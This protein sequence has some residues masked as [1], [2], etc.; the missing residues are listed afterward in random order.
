ME[1][2]W[3]LRRLVGSRICLQRKRRKMAWAEVGQSARKMAS[4]TIFRVRQTEACRAGWASGEKFV[5]A[6]LDVVRI[7]SEQQV[8]ME[9]CSCR[10]IAFCRQEIDVQQRLQALERQFDLPA[11][12]IKLGEAFGRKLLDGGTGDE[13]E[14]AGALERARIDAL[15]LI[16]LV[17]AQGFVSR[18]LGRLGWLGDDEKAHR[19][20]LE[21][22]ARLFHEHREFERLELSGAR[23]QRRPIERMGLG[24]G[25][26]ERVP[27]HTHNDVGARFDDAPQA[28]RLGVA[29]IGDDDILG[30]RIEPAK[31]LA[32]RRRRYL[33]FDD[34]RPMRV[35]ALQLRFMFKLC[36]LDVSETRFGLMGSSPE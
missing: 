20:R 21:T 10:F 1:S 25:Q 36:A 12:P 6:A 22:P 11:S 31:R 35:I 32:Y 4:A 8:S 2:I 33:G 30:L 14:K 34:T 15:A 26:L 18:L 9:P 7:E 23:E 24:I 19:K 5:Q 28:V 17:G 27:G 29:A 16:L 3:I 13:H